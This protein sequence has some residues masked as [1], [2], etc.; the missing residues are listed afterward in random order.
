MKLKKV[1]EFN[2]NQSQENGIGNLLGT[3]CDIYLALLI[4]VICVFMF[5]GYLILCVN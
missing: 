3:L 1:N 5:V 4:N 2:P